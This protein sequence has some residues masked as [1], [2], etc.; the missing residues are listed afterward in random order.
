MFGLSKGLILLQCKAE[1]SN[2]M[3]AVKRRRGIYSD[4]KIFRNGTFKKGRKE[5]RFILVINLTFLL[6]SMTDQ[7][8]SP[9]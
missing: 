7:I 5:G 1:K 2:Q 3:R 6:R 8:M 9:C 4:F